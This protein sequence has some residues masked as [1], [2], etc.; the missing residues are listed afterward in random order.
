LNRLA[1]A[2]ARDRND[3]PDLAGTSRFSAQGL[4]ILHVQAPPDALSPGLETIE[5]YASTV[6][7]LHAR[8]TILPLRFGSLHESLASFDDWLRVRSEEWQALLDEVEGCD[9]VGLRVL[10]DPGEQAVRAAPRIASDRP[11]TAYLHAL[12]TRHDASNCF[13]EAASRMADLLQDALAGT[14]RQSTIENPGPGRERLL[15]LNYLVPRPS[16]VQFRK[17]FE[18]FRGQNSARMLMTG[19]WPPYSFAGTKTAIF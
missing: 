1:L 16:L 4:A 3:L 19:P 6:A 14:F 11:G 13:L 8:E 18:P 9:E 12:K 7:S 2:I 15:S 5:A 17:A 10:L